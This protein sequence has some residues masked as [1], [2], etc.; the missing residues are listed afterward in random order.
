MFEDIENEFELDI[1]GSRDSD[2]DD[3]RKSSTE[4]RLSRRLTLGKVSLICFSTRVKYTFTRTAEKDRS[5][6]KF[7]VVNIIFFFCRI[8]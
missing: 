7:L 4:R 1:F 6:H 8:F 2:E 5:D 3:E